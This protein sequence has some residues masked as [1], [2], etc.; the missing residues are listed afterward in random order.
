MQAAKVVRAASVAVQGGSSSV[1]RTFGPLGE[2]LAAACAIN[3]QQSSAM[4]DLLERLA[5]VAIRA[6]H[7]A[8]QFCCRRVALSARELGISVSR[9]CLRVALSLGWACSADAPGWP[10]V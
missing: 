8:V 6:S 1:L 5:F 10:R 7:R 3:T 4:L 2:C 9:C